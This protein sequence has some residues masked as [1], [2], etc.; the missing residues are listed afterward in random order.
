MPKTLKIITLLLL[1]GV[2]LPAWAQSNSLT[3]DTIPAGQDLAYNTTITS[4]TLYTADS[5]I[6]IITACA[7]IC[8][9]VVSVY[10]AQT[11]LFIGN[12]NS[13]FTNAIFPE[14]YIEDKKI[15]WRNNTPTEWDNTY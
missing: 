9:S 12:I 7:P 3:I 8:S 14:A 10:N 2:V 4:D 11:N 6:V 13:P 5:I 1:I 15:L